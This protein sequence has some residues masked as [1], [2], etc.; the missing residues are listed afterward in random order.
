[1]LSALEPFQTKLAKLESE[2]PSINFREFGR[3]NTFYFLTAPIVFQVDVLSLIIRGKTIDDAPQLKNIL[4]S[5]PEVFIP[6]IHEVLAHT[7]EVSDFITRAQALAKRFQYD[8]VRLGINMADI[9]TEIISAK[10]TYKTSLTITKPNPPIVLSL[11]ASKEKK[12]E[13]SQQVQ[14]EA[15]K[16]T[17]KDDYEG[18]SFCKKGF[19]L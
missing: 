5:Y 11:E 15:S 3:A 12:E 4:R 18:V 14:P 16:T 8:L 1:M 13:K 6:T 19:L 9:I 17:T 7:Q 2:Y 10:D